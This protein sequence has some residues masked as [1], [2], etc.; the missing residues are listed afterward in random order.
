MEKAELPEESGDPKRLSGESLPCRG[1]VI[2][3]EVADV[4]GRAAEKVL[5]EALEVVPAQEVGI[6]AVSSARSSETTPF[7]SL[8]WGRIGRVR[9]PPL[10][11]SGT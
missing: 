8:V 3:A 7:R 11:A 6:F 1:D 10:C 2:E 5:V 4:N 9:G